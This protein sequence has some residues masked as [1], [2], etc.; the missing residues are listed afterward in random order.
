MA[1]S[2]SDQPRADQNPEES[3]QPE[4]SSFKW[5]AS[6]SS[7]VL[8]VSSGSLD[9]YS[10]EEVLEDTPSGE[11]QMS[12]LSLVSSSPSPCFVDHCIQIDEHVPDRPHGYAHVNSDD[13]EA[14]PTWDPLALET[15]WH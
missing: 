9:Y 13:M 5:N 12:E 8:L 7:L 1:E 2:D 11:Q 14:Q 10:C 3:I 6:S 15:S 4:S